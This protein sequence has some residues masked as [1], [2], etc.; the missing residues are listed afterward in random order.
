[1]E[2]G[3]GGGG[4]IHSPRAQ[5]SVS[6]VWTLLCSA[7]SFRERKPYSARL[8]TRGGVRRIVAR[9]DTGGGDGGIGPSF[10]S[11][12]LAHGPF[13]FQCNWPTNLKVPAHES[14]SFGVR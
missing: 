7:P 8:G 11:V 3:H 10:L 1:V 4:G 12:Q 6:E 13:F 5:S 9:V 14:H 2:I